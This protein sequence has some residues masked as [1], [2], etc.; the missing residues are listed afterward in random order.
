MAGV[1]NYR[2]DKHRAA[3]RDAYSWQVDGAWTE[4]IA[5]RF[6]RL[7]EPASMV[8]RSS[9][10][11][12]EDIRTFYVTQSS[13]LRAHRLYGLRLTNWSNLCPRMLSQTRCAES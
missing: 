1:A 8:G 3:V 6:G 13:D 9:L 7:D 11:R 10:A 2:L 5:E 4:R 12:D